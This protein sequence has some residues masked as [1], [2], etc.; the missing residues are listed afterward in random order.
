MSNLVFLN[1][2]FI[3]GEKAVLHFRDLSVQRGYGVFD[4]F[5]V[6]NSNPVFLEEHLSRFYY[7]AEEMRLT[8]GYTPD[9]LRKIIFELLQKNA[10]ADTGVRITLTGGYSEDGYQLSKPN[11]IL[12]L[13]SYAPPSKNQFEK[14]IKLITY[15]HQRQLPHVKT[16][17]Y[18]MGIWLQP[19]IRQNNADDVLYHQNGVVTESP[20]SNFFIVTQDEHIVTPSKNILKGIMRNKL[21]E[22]ASKEFIVEER[23]IT[24]NEIKTAKEAFLT[25]TTKTILPIRQLNEHVFKN[26]TPVS[27]HLHGLLSQLSNKCVVIRYQNT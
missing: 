3:P 5:K 13:H 7:S 27:A 26:I 1:D 10:T 24:I 22:V 16:I 2:Q 9:E 14:G 18:L 20:R 6:I 19:F 21:I 12:S 15:E 17:D 25:S 11:L 4:F 8:V 23:A